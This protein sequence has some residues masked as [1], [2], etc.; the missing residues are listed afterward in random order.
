MTI[1]ENYT[2]YATLAKARLIKV[3]SP[4][5]IFLVSRTKFLNK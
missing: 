5:R 3:K 1:K 4:Q 2:T